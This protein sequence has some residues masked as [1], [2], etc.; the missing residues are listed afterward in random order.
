VLAAPTV[1]E[2]A[3]LVTGP[4]PVELPTVDLPA[5]PGGGKPMAARSAS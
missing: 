1:A 4:P 3:E 2:L 5:V